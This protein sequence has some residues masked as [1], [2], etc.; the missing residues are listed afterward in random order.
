MLEDIM[1][2]MELP[3]ENLSIIYILGCKFLNFC[4]HKY[5]LISLHKE[6]TQSVILDYL[7]S[8]HDVVSYHIRQKSSI[9]PE[10]L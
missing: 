8:L 6:K 2:N 10:Y 4:G 5:M 9:Y 1:K 7:W 3:L